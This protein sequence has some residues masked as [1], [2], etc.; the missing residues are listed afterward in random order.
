[1][2]QKSPKITIN[3]STRGRPKVSD[4]VYKWMIDVGRGV[5]VLIELVA[6][7]ALVYR[8]IIDRQ[9]VDLKDEIRQQEAF[10]ERQTKDEALYRGIQTRLANI[11]QTTQDTSSKIAVMKVILGDIKNGTFSSTNLVVG[12]SSI[13]LTGNTFSIYTLNDF[14]ETIKSYPDVLSIN[15]D[16]I[17]TGDQGLKFKL[18]IRMKEIVVAKKSS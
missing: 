14:V 4:V 2:P 13:D 6:L 7:G 16:E 17:N 8:F 11:K 3:L 15:I 18:S 1:M 9:I 12:H 10:V 5:I